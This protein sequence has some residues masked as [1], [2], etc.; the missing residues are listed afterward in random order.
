LSRR[1]AT[2]IG[3]NTAES[4]VE[5][6]ALVSVYKFWNLYTKNTYNTRYLTRHDPEW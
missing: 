6:Q 2:I 1:N 5:P 4:S 3:K